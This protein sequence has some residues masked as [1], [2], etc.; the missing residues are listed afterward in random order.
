MP[1]PP[2]RSC[3]HPHYTAHPPEDRPQP[4]ADPGAEQPEVDHRPQDQGNGD[5]QPH[6]P[7]PQDD[8]TEE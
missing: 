3:Q 7:V 1:Q 6:P 4:P 5:V 8:G 2:H